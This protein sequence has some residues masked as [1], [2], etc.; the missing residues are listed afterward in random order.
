MYRPRAMLKKNVL[1]GT[2]N[3]GPQI[4]VGRTIVHGMSSLASLTSS[5]PTILLSPY[6]LGGLYSSGAVG[7]WSI[8]QTI[9]DEANTTRSTDG[10]CRTA[11]MTAVTPRRLAS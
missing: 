11:S 2:S 1:Y 7:R 3:H 9:R 6:G 5:S 4:E 10:V 8:R